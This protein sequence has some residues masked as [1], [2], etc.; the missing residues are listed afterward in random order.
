[1]EEIPVFVLDF[2]S[3]AIDAVWIM[4]ASYA[5]GEL[6]KLI[7]INKAKATE[8]YQTAKESAE[9][10]LNSLTSFELEHR[11]EYCATYSEDLYNRQLKRLLSNI[12]VSEKEY[13]EKYHLFNYKELKAKYGKEI[14]KVKLKELAK[15]NRL[16]RGDYNPDFFSVTIDNDGN[17]VPSQMYDEEKENKKNRITTA[18]TSM[19]SGFF[20][21]TFAGN[22]IFSFSLSVLFM[23]V[24]KITSVIIFASLK[25]NFGWNLVMKTGI[26]KYLLKAREVKNLKHYCSKIEQ[27]EKQ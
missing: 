16:K 1:V 26:N 12:D 14:P 9:T 6:F 10:A 19:A 15:I 8:E 18:I 5:I 24:V 2:R 13:L 11:A 7:F 27:G 21:V 4:V 22:F 25:A 17:L 23:A 3:L 20:C